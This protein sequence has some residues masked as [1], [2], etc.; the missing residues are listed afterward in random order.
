MAMRS[1]LVALL[2]ILSGSSVLASTAIFYSG[3]VNAVL[4][5]LPDAPKTGVQLDFRTLE[6]GA[7][8]EDWFGPD[9]SV[10]SKRIG[11]DGAG[12]FVESAIAFL[13]AGGLVTS[14]SKGDVFAKTEPNTY[15]SLITGFDFTENPNSAGVPYGPYFSET[16]AQD[17]YWGFAFAGKTIGL[18]PGW[19]RVTVNPVIVDR[20]NRTFSGGE[21]I[22]REWAY[23]GGYD[24]IRVGQIPEPCAILPATLAVGAFA[25]ARVSRG[26]RRR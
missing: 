1:F 12:T 11:E 22:L 23:D 3:E 24:S 5:G 14:L 15:L 16:A 9:F 2:A 10:E 18:M 19:M 4:G 7:L 26:G 20:D 8:P 6:S 17:F 25:A 21:I 13:G